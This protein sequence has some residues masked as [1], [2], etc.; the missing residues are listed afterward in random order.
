MEQRSLRTHVLDLIGGFLYEE[1]F[2]RCAY[3]KEGI[4]NLI[5]AT[6]AY[7]EEGQDLYPEV[8][9]TDNIDAVLQS[10]PFCKRVEIS[11]KPASSMEFL[12]A[13]KLCAPLS[14]NGWV[15]YINVEES[16]INYGLVSSEI[17][18]LSP[19]FHKHSV[20]ELSESGYEY[21]I[22]YLQNVGNKSVFLRGLQ[23]SALISLSLNDRVN[24]I[25]KDL[26]SICNTIASDIDESYRSICSA[27]FEKIIGEAL[28]TGHGSLIAVV[29]DEPLSIAKMQKKHSDGIYL[30]QP[31]DIFDFVM[32]SEKQKTREAS[33]SNTLHSSLVKSM[34]HHDG[35]TILTTQGKVLGYHIFVKP[36]GAENEKIIGGARSRAF[37]ILKLSNVFVSCFYKSQDGSEKFWSENNVQ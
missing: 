8:F 29:K 17:S 33:T 30:P 13:L 14:K 16:T 25:G 7:R 2:P 5:D 20:G 35:V 19:S 37:E 10:L 26:Q 27:Y 6:S 28:I 12:Q 15:I 31:I 32:Q 22:A 3:L 11:N 34:L 24:N 4:L 21:A 18:E 1:K 23:T 9:I 36:E